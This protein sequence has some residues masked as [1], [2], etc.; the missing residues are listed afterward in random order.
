MDWDFCTE[1][2]QVARKDYQCDA[3]DWICNIGYGENEYDPED[4]AAIEKARSEGC[5]ILKGQIYV[6]VS[7]KWDGEMS[8]FRARPE[9]NDICRKYEIYS[10]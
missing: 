7:G 4:W 9:I 5:K 2:K 8:V 1:S 6:K 3:M 10:D